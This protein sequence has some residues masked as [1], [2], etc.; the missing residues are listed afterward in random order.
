MNKIWFDIS[1]PAQFNFYLNA[2]KLLSQQNKVY[3]SVLDRGKLSRIARKE[4]EAL[5]S[6][7][8]MIIGK[9]LGTKTSAIY[10]ANILR[11][12]EFSRKMLKV[13]PAVSVGNGFLHC[14]SATLLNTPSIAFN[15]DLERKVNVSLMKRFA[16]ELFHIS[17][18]P[19]L[20]PK[21]GIFS[22]YSLKEWA[23]L[24]P[25][26][27]VPDEKVLEKYNLDSGKYIFVREVITGTLNY[28]NQNRNLIASV[29]DSFPV[30]YKVL[31]SLEDKTKIDQYPSS[32]VL[33]EEPVED[34]HSLIF[35]SALLVSSGD[36]MAREGAVLGVPSIYCG[37]REMMANKMMIDKGM[38]FFIDISEVPERILMLA[39]SKTEESQKK[40]INELLNEWVDV[41]ELIV[42]TINKYLN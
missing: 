20:N 8:L 18:S 22:F 14:I 26:Y 42:S 12:L 29:S 30:D 6:C 21:N 11:V 33:L 41:T 7:E 16:S 23:Y 9:H 25:S 19:D 35:F 38:L 1:H 28:N 40:I 39:G 2:I 34:I 15:D 32:W 13:K 17:E 27:F 36:S 31:L 37:V 4:L 5:S 3:V 24:S 10:H